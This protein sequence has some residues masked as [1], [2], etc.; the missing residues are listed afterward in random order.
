LGASP[1][2]VGGTGPEPCPPAPSRPERWTVRAVALALPLACWPLGF[3]VFVL[4]KLAVL[5]IAV[6]ALAVL[7]IAS[8]I[9]RRRPALD[10]PLAALAGSAALSTALSINPTLSLFGAYERYEGLVTILCCAALCW[11]AAQ[12]LDGHEAWTVARLLVAAGYV[13]A[14]LGIVQSLVGGAMLAGAAAETARTFGGL[15]RSASTFGNANALGMY[16]AM[17]LPLAAYDL[18]RARSLADRLLAANVSGTLGL[19]LLLTFSRSAWLGALLGV[20]VACGGPMVAAARRR[21]RA[22]LS[23]AVLGLAAAAVAAAATPALHPV[24]GRAASLADPAAGSMAT[25]LRI[26]R[27]AIDLIRARPL[28]GW[29]PDTFGLVYPRFQTGDWTPG[30]DVDRA[31]AELLDVAAGRGLLGVTVYLALLVALAVAFWRGRRR[32]GA[33]AVMG[34]LVAYQLA[35]QFNFS[36]LPASAPFW[37]LAAAALAIWMD[38]RPTPM[39]HATGRRRAA[40][41]ALLPALAAMAVALVAAPLA[42]DALFL[43]GLA[44]S[45]AGD[46]ATARADVEAARRLAPTQAVYAAAAGDLALALDRSDRPGPDADLPAAR[47][48][49]RTAIALGDARPAVARH[50]ATASGSQSEQGSQALERLRA[51]RYN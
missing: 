19:G 1:R 29:G 16:L 6:L 49:Y 10:L 22:W 50:L 9:P 14:L 36:W 26:W 43:R 17:V 45:A 42:A 18:L 27:D 8:R 37:L 30:F 44:A 4:P 21:P 20:F 40:V 23:G 15:V 5:R 35:L 41:T 28:A 13:A 47:S 48:A 11:L 7:W 33:G 51:A 25:R 32:A 38:P 3:D 31:H 24:L 12:F 46:R 39:T 34:G 2:T